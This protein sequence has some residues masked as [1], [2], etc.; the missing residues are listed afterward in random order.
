MSSGRYCCVPGCKERGADVMY[1]SSTSWVPNPVVDRE[2]FNTWLITVSDF[3]NKYHQTAF[4]ANSEPTINIISGAIYK[5]YKFVQLFIS[6]LT[7]TMQEA[8]LPSTSETNVH[9]NLG[10]K[11]T[12]KKAKSR[13]FLT[14][15]EK[16]LQDKLVAASIKL[17]KM[18]NRFKKLS[19]NVKAAKQI[20]SN[21]AAISYTFASSATKGPERAQQIKDVIRGLQESGFI[22]VATVCDQGPNNRQ[23]LKLLINE[24][25]GIYLRKGED[26]KENKILINGQEIVPLYD[27]MMMT[28]MTSPQRN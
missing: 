15:T 4:A 18:K 1:A 27:L 12:V 10:E 6:G 26:P 25:R 17:S 7:A 13:V 22:V 8:A 21:P 3:V 2:G 24:N 28:L 19:V 5:S 14:N 9:L 16:Y 23:A 11:T 20:A